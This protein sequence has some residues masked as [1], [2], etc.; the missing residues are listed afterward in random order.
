MSEQSLIVWVCLQCLPPAL[1]S[2]HSVNESLCAHV[3]ISPA[4]WWAGHQYLCKAHCSTVLANWQADPA[5]PMAQGRAL[6]AEQ[7]FLLRRTFHKHSV[8]LLKQGTSKKK[9]KNLSV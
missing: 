6:A 8:S 3:S 5:V 1:P 2:V 7:K 4:L 9:K